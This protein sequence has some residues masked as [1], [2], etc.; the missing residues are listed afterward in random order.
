MI[1]RGAAL[2][3]ALLSGAA[4]QPAVPARDLRPVVRVDVH[5]RGSDGQPVAGLL[6]EDF[7]LREDGA[8]QAVS[9][10]EHV[11]VPPSSAGDAA[12]A[13][14]LGPSERTRIVVVFLDTLHLDPAAA[15]ALHRPLVR[16]LDQVLRPED[17]VAVMT[18]EMSA[19]DILFGR[20]AAGSETALTRLAEW[21]QQD[22]RPRVSDEDRYDACFPR[23]EGC[24]IA[25]E[26]TS[27]RR[28][29]RV[30]TALTDLTRTLEGVNDGLKAVVTISP[31][32]RLHRENLALARRGAC[33]KAS[34]SAD[35]ADQ[36]IC[37]S[38]RRRLAQLNVQ[39]EFRRMIDGANRAT[40]SFYPLDVSAMASTAAEAGRAASLRTLAEDTSGAAI[41]HLDDAA[42]GFGRLAG[43][44]GD[45]YLLGYQSTNPRLD[46]GSRRIGVSVL[47]NGVAVRARRGYRVVTAGELD[48]IR[49][50]AAAAGQNVGGVAGAIAG[51]QQLG[52]QA[53]LAAR[54]AY[55][56]SG[57][58]RVRLW[59][60]GELA[61]ATAREGAWLGGGAADASLALPDN[62]AVASGEGA[63]AAGQRVV[64]VELGEVEAP[65]TPTSLRLRVRPSGDEG[66]PRT[67]EILLAPVGADDAGVPLLLRRGP[68]TGGRFAPTA[69]LRFRR[70][71]RIRLELPRAAPPG[72]FEAALLDRAGAPLPLAVATSVRED[73]GQT[74][75]VAEVS[76]APL[77]HGDFLVRLTVDGQES[78]TAFRVV[79]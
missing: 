45:Y 9:S 28:E 33:D 8:P 42:G 31:G 17:V 38:D 16:L 67:A 46:G 52:A 15:R 30:M 43:D 32:W 7:D 54:V 27:R 75:A 6:A 12:A 62:R 76:L 50:A 79:P 44:L 11:V 41:A 60:I 64:L 4:V 71:E 70:T 61:T 69:D 37:E 10:F 66:A 23:G 20:R 22:E 13:R 77:A 2:L 24:A 26:M 39:Y 51:L 40:V 25:E 29:Q 49:T 47:R 68:T 19:R 18:P 78:I 65:T 57:P 55:G 5:V 63:L 48:R 56:P 72:R 53:P 21:G 36:A 58:G 74:W 1:A 73:D 14:P 3:A 34:A 35:A 59:A